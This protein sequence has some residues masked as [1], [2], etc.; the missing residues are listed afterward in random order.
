MK[1][2]FLILLLISG[3][4]ATSDIFPPSADRPVIADFLPSPNN[5][6]YCATTGNNSTGD[7]SIGNPWLDLRGAT[8]GGAGT[9]I[10]A[11]DLLYLRGGTYPDTEASDSEYSR[12]LNSLEIDG[13]S[14]NPI[15]VTNYPGEIAEWD[16]QDT[17]SL[18]LRGDYL[19]LVGT[20]VGSSYGIVIDGGMTVHE[21]D[22]FRVHNVEFKSGTANGGDK[23][24]AMLADPLDGT[25]QVGVVISHNYFHDDIHHSLYSGDWGQ[26][27]MV[28]SMTNFI[29]E[30][31]TFYNMQYLY[32]AT[33]TVKSDIVNGIIRYN[34]FISCEDG[35]S[36][37]TQGND[38]NGLLIYENLFNNSGGQN[39]I[40]VFRSDLTNNS[41]PI[42]VY[43]NVSISQQG[44]FLYYLNV[45]NQTWTE[46][47]D[48][49]NN[50]IDGVAVEEGWH[51]NSSDLDNLP[52]LFDYN[53]WDSSS[54]R[55][56][57]S[58]WTWP[59]GYF[60]NAVTNADLGLT[61]NATTQTVTADDDYPGLG[62]GISSTNIGGFTF[63]GGGEPPAQSTG[64][65]QMIPGGQGVI[66]S[67]GQGKME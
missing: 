50:I 54:D 55:T 2:L 49:Y 37:G 27:I 23:N 60:D 65:G 18:T 42:A 8:T 66:H 20:M 61:Y 44:P 10:A 41:N 13:T 35:I 30:Y 53:L 36:Y 17:W 26:A 57:P 22:Y 3:L 46:H 43:N 4:Y 39:G 31:N 38:T 63:E 33:V 64:N 15:V 59:S 24:P 21:G 47:G 34:K 62:V 6:Y 45:D 40:I 25:S 67:G 58:G 16:D 51:G 5:T 1:R 29:V 14:G 7:G 48:Y 52:D 56:E 32:S 9:A 19:Y 11:G 12:S 28:F